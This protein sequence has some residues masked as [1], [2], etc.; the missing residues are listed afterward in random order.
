VRS[1]SLRHF[2]S[3]IAKSLNVQIDLPLESAE[4]TISR[5]AI[6]GLIREMMPGEV[7]AWKTCDG[8]TYTADDISR[9][10]EQGTD[11]GHQYARDVL[12]VAIDSLRRQARQRRSA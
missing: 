1:P 5:D 11:V 8:H 4:R 2:L 7:V 3:W 12:R 9:E 6:A 10:V